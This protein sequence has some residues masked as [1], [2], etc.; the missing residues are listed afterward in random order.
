MSPVPSSFP[1]RRKVSQFL[2]SPT[3]L[4]VGFVVLLIA[5]CPNARGELMN[6][7]F[8]MNGGLPTADLTNLSVPVAPAA[9]PRVI[10]RSTKFDGPQASSLRPATPSERGERTSTATGPFRHSRSPL[11]LLVDPILEEGSQASAGRISPMTGP[12]VGIR[13]R[14]PNPAR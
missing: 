5:T 1:L 2:F 3:G 14:L 7:M 6:N 11:P 12:T 8:A 13:P 4:L 9:A 10:G